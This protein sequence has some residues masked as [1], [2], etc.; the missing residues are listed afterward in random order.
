VANLC[1]VGF[2]PTGSLTQFQ[3][4][5]LLPIPCD[6]AFLAHQDLTLSLPVAPWRQIAKLGAGRYFQV[7][8]SGS[9][10]AIATP[11]DKKM[12]ALSAKLD[13][14][15]LY[16]G[17]REKKVKQARKQ[18]ATAKLNAEASVTSRARRAAF[19]SSASGKKNLLGEGE[20][21]EDV[22]SGQV[23]L[24]KIPKDALPKPMQAMAPAAQKALVE[25]TAE[26]RK[27]LQD[28]IKRLARERAE[29]LKKK[30]AAE[31]GARDSLDD[32][33]FATVRE[34]AASAGIHYDAG[35]APRY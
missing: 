6:Q 13:A 23:D 12:A 4:N 18:A 1:R 34:Q 17:D 3:S 27:T 2:Q 19:N 7:D 29:Y 33:L 8:Q 22:T 35:A 28:Q 20:L 21:V 15:R 31:G 14:T 24:A 16:Y 26:K 25:K 10:V 5:F 30:V 9:A 11:F 32:K